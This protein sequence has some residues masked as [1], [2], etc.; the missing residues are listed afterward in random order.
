MTIVAHGK[1]SKHEVD[2]RKKYPDDILTVDEITM[3]SAGEVVVKLDTKNA[4]GNVHVDAVRLLK[5]K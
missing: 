5:V 3:T 2:Q 4:G 1:E